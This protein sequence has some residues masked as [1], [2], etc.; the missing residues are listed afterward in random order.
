MRIVTLTLLLCGTI[1]FAQD[2]AEV[3]EL[4]WGKDD[5]AKKNIT[6][7][8]KWKKESAV[9]I[10]K[11]ENYDYH[12][13][14]TSVT[15]I[16]STRKRIKLQDQASVKEFS[17]FS[18]RERFFSNKAYGWKRGTNTIGIKV[19]K[20]DG[21]E[22]EID[23]DAEAITTDQT[24]K[25]AIPN[26]EVGDIIDFYFYTKEPFKSFDAFGFDPVETTVADSYPIMDMKLTL[27]TENDFFINFNTYNGAP[28]LMEVS[29]EGSS[30]RRYELV[31]NDVEKN[32]FPRWFYPLVELPC[33]K[34]QVYFAR[35]GKFEESAG[36]FLP[37]KE[38]IIKKN[39]STDDVL[40]YYD[41]R[42]KPYGN[43]G[44]IKTYLKEH[45]FTSD[46][47]KVKQ[48]Y[49]YTRHQYYTRF[50]EAFVVKE[51]KIMYPWEYYGMPVFFNSEEEF[52]NHFMAFLKDQKLDYD[53]IVA[54]PRNNGPIKDLLL[55]TNIEVL[56]RVNT[57][58]PVYLQFFTPYTNADQVKFLIENSDAYALKVSKGKK[59]SDIETIKLPVSTHKDNRSERKLDV[60]FSADFNTVNL[61]RE[62]SLYGHL[63]DADQ[64]DKM[65]FFDYVAEDYAKYGT[66]SLLDYVK[67]KKKKEQYTNEFDALKNK[68]K[69]KQKKEFKESIESEFDFTVEDHT[70]E[71][72]ATG[73]F[74]AGTPFS[75]NEKFTVKDKLVKKA[76]ANY[77]L[78][79]G[80]LIGEQVNIEEKD[81]KRAN[82][83][84]QSYPRA[85]NE[86]VIITIPDGYTVSGLEKLNK[87]VEN[88]T[89]GFV[90]TAT[91]TGNKLT[92]KATKYYATYYEPAANWKDI[93][94]F[95]DAAYQ[96]TQEKILLKKN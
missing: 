66:K 76:G 38:N 21:T 72:T 10:Y 49:Y 35:S 12:K 51:A 26:L 64:D 16:S 33:Y 55:K 71:V 6:V 68:L 58:N 19:I 84:Y 81:K 29:P 88:A 27:K 46:E 94:A 14:G 89:G 31:A 73:R 5:P 87:K 69:E 42:F 28:E 20:P 74:G 50:V 92:V 8:E 67:N 1:T 48:V 2:K 24:K 43:L 54:T 34:F 9:V 52:I 18:F 83:I 53:I 82:N 45:T 59:V 11:N 7:P 95:I 61:I 77:V 57:Q 15:Y 91:L 85:Y 70:L 13:Y 60:T 25:I 86:E 3:K 40:A 56:L 36:G 63:K 93:T 47:E 30:E 75:Y 22:K 41:G 17:E 80:K 90:S 37:K 4:F 78:E 39:V 32:D 44:D 65:Y 96:F 62:S 79:V 23:V